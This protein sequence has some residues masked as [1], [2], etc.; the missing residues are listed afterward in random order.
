MTLDRLAPMLLA[1]NLDETIAFYTEGLGFTLESTLDD[2]PTWCSLRRDEVNLMFVWEG[3]HDHA[4]GDEHNHPELGLPGVLYVYP[5]EV[6]DLYDEVKDRVEI[7]EELGVRT[8]G[9]IEF[10]VLDPNGYRLRFGG[11]A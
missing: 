11:D 6:Q 10:A 7:C 1:H 8:H 9:M 5:S 3:E 2:P 4:P